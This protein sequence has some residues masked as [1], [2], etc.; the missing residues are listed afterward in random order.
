MT[1]RQCFAHAL[2]ILI[3]ADAI[4]AYDV[5]EALKAMM[6]DAFSAAFEKERTGM[7]FLRF[8]FFYLGA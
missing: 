5:D 6:G 7:E 1:T 4:R 3:G 2:G 8:A